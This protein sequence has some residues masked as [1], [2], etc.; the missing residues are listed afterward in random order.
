MSLVRSF[1]KPCIH[2][3]SLLVQPVA[4]MLPK[5]GVQ[6][7]LKLH[8]E[9]VCTSIGKINLEK[10]AKNVQ[11]VNFPALLPREIVR[12][13]NVAKIN[14]KIKRVLPRAGNAPRASILKACV[15]K[16]SALIK[17]PGKV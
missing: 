8:V 12:A 3:T 16:N 1:Q 15:V 5:F 14:T 7:I 11:Q 9:A 10:L 17:K 2:I 6:V 4:A 13:E